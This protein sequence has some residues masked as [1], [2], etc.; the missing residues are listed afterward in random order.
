[1]GWIKRGLSWF[2]GRKQKPLTCGRGLAGPR[3][4]PTLLSTQGDKEIIREHSAMGTEQQGGSVAGRQTQG[5]SVTFFS[6]LFAHLKCHHVNM[7]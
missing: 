7:K 2:G 1:M 5:M 6:S 3:G 4:F